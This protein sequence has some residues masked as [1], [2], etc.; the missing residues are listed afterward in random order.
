MPPWMSS[1]VREYYTARDQSMIGAVEMAEGR[2]PTN[3]ELRNHG[4]IFCFHDGQEQFIWK[5]IPL[6][7]IE[8]F[9]DWAQKR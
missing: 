2:V 1:L 9:W 4:Q 8:S 6:V 7:A 5:E 3:D